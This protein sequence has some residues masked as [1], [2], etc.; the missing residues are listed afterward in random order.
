MFTYTHTEETH[1]YHTKIIFERI[2]IPVS[3]ETNYLAFLK[4][5]ISS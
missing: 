5:S 1:R 4:H 3:A 2:L